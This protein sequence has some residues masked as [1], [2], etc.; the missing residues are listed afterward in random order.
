MVPLVPVAAGVPGDGA[1]G[2]GGAGGVRG[3]RGGVVLR[4]GQEGRQRR[5]PGG[6]GSGDCQAGDL[7]Q[8][9]R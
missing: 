6:P 2:R 5:W 1:R 4:G 9:R 3:G 8:D 7:V